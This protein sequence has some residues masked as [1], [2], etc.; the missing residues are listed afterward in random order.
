MIVR[1]VVGRQ[2]NDRIGHRIPP[3]KNFL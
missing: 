3:F 1:S 2:G